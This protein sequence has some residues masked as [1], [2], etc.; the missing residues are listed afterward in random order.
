MGRFSDAEA[1][2]LPIMR[3]NRGG[4]I[5]PKIDPYFTNNQNRR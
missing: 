4:L 5:T 1:A 3:R 2:L